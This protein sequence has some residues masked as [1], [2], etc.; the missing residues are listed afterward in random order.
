MHIRQSA[1]S[2][3]FSRNFVRM[4]SRRFSF[5]KDTPLPRTVVREAH[6]V[7]ALLRGILLI[8]GSCALLGTGARRKLSF[9]A[10]RAKIETISSVVA[11]KSTPYSSAY[12]SIVRTRHALHVHAHRRLDLTLKRPPAVVRRALR[13]ALSLPASTAC[14]QPRRAR[15]TLMLTERTGQ[16]AGGVRVLPAQRSR[17]LRPGVG[18]PTSGNATPEFFHKRNILIAP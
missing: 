16:T 18:A 10:L 6:L 12:A 9:S 13:A 1:R 15:M 8:I 4:R 7:E 3:T 14:R 5:G 11:P 17:S 2:S